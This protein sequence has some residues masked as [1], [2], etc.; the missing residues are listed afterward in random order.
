MNKYEL[1]YIID[2]AAEE[3]T[4]KELIEKFNIPLDEYPR[5]CVNQINGWKKQYKDAN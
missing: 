4:R 2:T 1:I 3:T 5:R